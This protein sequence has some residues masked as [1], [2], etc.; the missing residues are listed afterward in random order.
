METS[1]RLSQRN[2]PTALEVEHRRELEEAASNSPEQFFDVF[3]VWSVAPSPLFE[4]IR[5]K[6]VAKAHQ[7]M[8]EFESLIVV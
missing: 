7:V 8:A 5:V 2:A 3:L 6:V 1:S 4:V